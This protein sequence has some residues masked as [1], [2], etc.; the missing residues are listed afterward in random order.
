MFEVPAAKRLKRS[1]LFD[2]D[3]KDVL[4]PESDIETIE[5]NE[6]ENEPPSYSF[7]YDL[8]KQ[9]PT[10]PSSYAQET[11]LA[12]EEAA[13]QFNLF[14]PLAKPVTS[15]TKDDNQLANAQPD[16]QPALISLR[17]PSPP[18]ADPAKPKFRTHRAD[19]YY[20]TAS[21]SPS[22][23][24]CLRNAY[25]QSAIS[26]ATVQALCARSWPGAYLPWRVVH[27]P[28]HRKQVL[29]H[30]GAAVVSL[31]PKGQSSLDDVKA[32]SR[33]RP[34]KK[35]RDLLK[36]KAERR[37]RVVDESK[38]KEE[39]EKEKKNKKNRERKLKRRAK[40]RKEKEE[41]RAVARTNGEDEEE[42]DDEDSGN[43][44]K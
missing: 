19:S 26:A 3:P 44:V 18:A 11:D 8:V 6:S 39:H 17:S 34:S 13:F 32:R 25:S 4:G 5:N 28:A 30:K 31:S 15:K 43:E 27:L 16:P 38:T 9:Q 2:Y 10:T 36:L 12:K 20:F 23:L 7:E 37:Q 24:T 22:R 14:R 1:E 40:E 29:V 41:K 21:I 35:R 42:K 33:A